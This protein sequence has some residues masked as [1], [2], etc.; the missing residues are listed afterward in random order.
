MNFSK[1]NH[2][3]RKNNKN[4]VSNKPILLLAL[5]LSISIVL[6]SC[7]ESK[8]DE[9]KEHIEH[10]VEKADLA[11]NDVYQCPM[12]CENGKTYEK[13]GICPVCEM[14]LKKVEKEGEESESSHERHDHDNSD[15]EENESEG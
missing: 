6:T 7:K 1:K 11:M 10:G 8:K 2:E 13:E 12:D 14:D 15:P 4:F 3:H 9:T 5:F